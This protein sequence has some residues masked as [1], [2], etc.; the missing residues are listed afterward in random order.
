MLIGL[1]A[2]SAT[3]P[4]W[5]AEIRAQGSLEADTEVA[6][7]G[8][9]VLTWDLADAGQDADFVLQRA[10]TPDFADPIDRSIPTAGS[11]TITGLEDGTYHF[12]AGSP[13]AGW[14]PTVAVEVRHHALGRAFGFF[15]LGLVL[16][17]ILMATIFIGHRNTHTRMLKG[18]APQGGA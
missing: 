12:R 13:I 10:R 1:I 16:F 5:S 3:I 9:M 8:Y 6:S 4:L 11:V 17:A 2:L 18:K 7:E 14:S 15:S